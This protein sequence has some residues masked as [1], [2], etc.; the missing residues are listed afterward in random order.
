[1]MISL[2]LKSIPG[3]SKSKPKTDGSK[4]GTSLVHGI[5]RGP[6]PSLVVVPF[7]AGV[8]S[9]AEVV[10]VPLF[11]AAEARC[12]VDPGGNP[13]NPWWESPGALVPPPPPPPPH[14]CLSIPLP[15]L[16]SID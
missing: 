2:W 12:S 10:L 4:E 6:K 5:G 8:P 11:R 3:S 16:P 13:K 15:K 9:A 7:A 1:M 14:C